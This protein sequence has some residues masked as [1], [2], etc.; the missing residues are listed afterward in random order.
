MVL[1]CGL[2][3]LGLGQTDSRARPGAEGRFLGVGVRF[4][5]GARG[6]SSSEPG[7]EAPQIFVA[8]SYGNA[9]VCLSYTS[10]ASK[11]MNLG[12]CAFHRLVTQGLF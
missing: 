5:C 1:E 8:L 12:S 4:W 10:N 3:V 2:A 7:A 9:S 11:L 6:C